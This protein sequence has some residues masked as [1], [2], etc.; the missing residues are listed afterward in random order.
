MDPYK[1]L[2]QAMVVD[3]QASMAQLKDWGMKEAFAESSE[4]SC[5]GQNLLSIYL[6]E[7]CT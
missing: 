2:M 4:T 5:F 3:S 1:S 7:L 6:M